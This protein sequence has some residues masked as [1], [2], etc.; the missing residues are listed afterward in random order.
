ME[1]NNELQNGW[2]FASQVCAENFQANVAADEAMF[3]NQLQEAIEKLNYDINNDKMVNTPYYFGFVQEIFATDTFN[4]NAIANRSKDYAT[5]PEST[6]Y[7]S[8]DIEVH[9]SNGI[10][11]YS[12]KAISTPEKSAAA[13]AVLN[14]DTKEA[15]YKNQG[16]LVPSDHLNKG[17][18][19]LRQREIKNMLTRE[20]VAEAYR[21]TNEKLT[22]KISNNDGVQSI[23]KTKK[24]YVKMD[25]AAKKGEFDAADWGIN[26]N[27]Y[28]TVQEVITNALN[29]G[30]TAAVINTALQLAPDLYKAVDYLIKNGELDLNQ[31]SKLREKGI[32]SSAEGFLRGTASY[33]VVYACQ[34]GKFGENLKKVDPTLVGSI[35]SILLSTIKYSILVAAGEMTYKQLA[36]KTIDNVVCI[37]GFLAG[38]KIGAKIGTIIGIEAPIFGYVI[39]SLIG[40]AISVVYSIGKNKMISFCIE[41]GFTCFGLVEQN[42]ELPERE[43]KKIGINLADVH[44]ANVNH[45]EIH[46]IEVNKPVLESETNKYETIDFKVLKRGLIGVN[47]VGYVYA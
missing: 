4:I 22:S 29:A 47:K 40:S 9:T 15:L 18:E 38:Q 39:G 27:N 24:Q 44:F 11:N 7:G 36:E 28:V 8:V 43:L 17:K 14:R 34:I 31:V 35:V 25:K 6:E 10:K 19:Y 20:N 45:A 1:K 42:Y 32:S 33:L 37:G 26:I 21:E 23:A 30:M 16:R 3:F 13:Q 41:S 2:E 5:R 12:A 46:N